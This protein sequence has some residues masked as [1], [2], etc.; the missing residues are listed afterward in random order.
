MSKEIDQKVVEMQFDNRNFEQNVQTS[1]STIEKLKSK[2]DFSGSSKGFDELSKAAKNVDLSTISDKLDGIE[3]KIKNTFSFENLLKITGVERFANHLLDTVQ[4]TFKSLTTENLAAG[5]EKFD[6]KTSG[7]ATLTSQGFAL[8]EVNAQLERLNWFTDETSYNF[9]DMEREI[10]KFTA[11]GQGLEES[12]TAMEGIAS[13]AA[14]SGQKATTASRAM[15]QLSQAMSKGALKYDDYRSIQNASMDT[16]EFRLEAAKTAAELGILEQT[17]EDTFRLMSYDD[18]GNFTGYSKEYSLNDLFTSD[19]LTQQQ[20]FDTDV[21]MGVFTKYA[22]AADG[23]YEFMNSEAGE[24][25]DTV[26]EAMSAIEKEA[27]DY[28]KQMN[29]TGRE[30]SFDEALAELGY[31]FDSFALKAFKAGQEARSFADVLDATKD[32]VSTGWMNTFQNIFGD[33]EQAK[34]LWTDLATSFYNIFASGAEERNKVLKE[35]SQAW[36]LFDTAGN[37]INGRDLLFGNTKTFK[38]ALWIVI[39][40]IQTL[41]DAFNEAKEEIFGGLSKD[42]LIDLSKGIYYL[43][44]SIEITEE[45]AE[46]FKRTFKGMFAIIDVV[47][48]IIKTV[49]SSALKLVNKLMGKSDQSVLDLSADLGDQLVLFREWYYTVKDDF[50]AALDTISNV[51]LGAK[52]KVEEFFGVVENT[53]AYVAVQDVFF[54]IGTILQTFVDD[55]INGRITLDSFFTVL[56]QVWNV[57]SDS[58]GFIIDKI[59]EAVE[60][61]KGFFDTLDINWDVVQL[62]G[63]GALLLLFAH[64]FSKMHE[65]FE[66]P[67]ERLGELISGFSS[68]MKGFASDLKAHSIMMIAEAIAILAISIAALAMLPIENVWSALG[69]IAALGVALLAFSITISKVGK[70]GD[71]KQAASGAIILGVA[72]AIAIV[73]AVTKMIMGVDAESLDRSLTIIFGIGTFLAVLAAGLTVISGRLSTK[74]FKISGGDKAGKIVLGLAASML[75]IGLAIKLIASIDT[76]DIVKGLAVIGIISLFFT[77]VA[78]ASRS[79]ERSLNQTTLANGITNQHGKSG[80][81]GIGST[82]VALAASMLIISAAIKSIAKINNSDLEKGLSVIATM[83]LIFAGVMAL[84]GLVGIN[85]SKAGGLFLGLS[86][87]LLIMTAVIK[88]IAGI[89]KSEL[90]TGV[91]NLN[92]VIFMFGLVMAASHFAG[93]N[94]AKAG[95]MF[96][97]MSVAL[98]ILTGVIKL[99][100]NIDPAGLA[101]GVAAIDALGLM[102]GAVMA[103]SALTGDSKDVLTVL[104]VDLGLL[105]LA[106]GVLSAMEPGRLLAAAG[107]MVMVLAALA[108]VLVATKFA[109]TSNDTDDL[110]STIAGIGILVA[111]IGIILAALS[112]LPLQNTLANAAALSI[113]FLSLAGAMMMIGKVEPFKKGVFASTQI[114]ALVLTEISAILLLF[115]FGLSALGVPIE[116]LITSA[117]ALAVLFGVFGGVFAIISAVGPFASGALASSQIMALA[118][119]EVAAVLVAYSFGLNALGV[120]METLVISASVLAVLLGT[121]GGVFAILSAIGPFA[122]GAM[123]SSQIMALTMIEIAG[124]LVAFG[125]GLTAL[126]IPM[127]TLVISAGTLAVLFGVFGGVF[128]ILSAI[129]PFASGAMASTQIMSLTMLEIAGVLLAFVYGINSLGIP[130]DTLIMSSV[131]LSIL[132][133]AFGGVFAIIAALSPLAATAIAGVGVFAAFIAIMFGI[134]VGIGELVK[135]IQGLGE[136]ISTGISILGDIGLGIGKFVGNIVA[137]VLGNGLGGA[138][139]IIADSLNY[140]G[141]K[142][143]PFLESMSNVPK[144][145][146]DGVGTIAAIILELSGASIVDAFSSFLGAGLNPVG[147]ILDA[148]SSGNRGDGIDHFTVMLSSLAN[149]VKVFAEATKDIDVDPERV[150]NVA[151]AALA[152]A[153]AESAIPKH[154]GVVSWF[155]GDNSL[156]SFSTGIT[157]LAEGLSTFVEKTKNIK[158]SSIDKIKNSTEAISCLVELSK[159]LPK[160]NGVLQFFT[161]HPG[162]LIAFGSEM[163][164][165]GYYI[166]QYTE[167][168]KDTDFN[169]VEESTTAGKLIIDMASQLPAHNGLLQ[170]ILGDNDLS[171]FG[172]SLKDFADGMVEYSKKI[173]GLNVEAI[174]K[175]KDAAQL[176]SD[177]EAGL[178]ATSDSIS[179]W[180]FGGQSLDEFGEKLPKLADGIKQFSD[181]ITEGDGINKAAINSATTALEVLSNIESNLPETTGVF[182]WLTG[183]DK[184]ID[185]FTKDMPKFAEGI[186]KFSD[187]L[188][189]DGGIDSTAVDAAA[190]AMSALSLLSTVQKITDAK[191]VTGKLPDMAEDL[192]AYSDILK[193]GDGFDP[194]TVDNVTDAVK[195]IYA[196]EN[197]LVD[198]DFTRIS[199]GFKKLTDLVN[200]LAR[201]S[202]LDSEKIT[203]FGESLKT[204]ADGGIS[205]FFNAFESSDDRL[206]DS[207]VSMLNAFVRG[208]QENESKFTEVFTSLSSAGAGAINSKYDEYKEAGK[209]I[210]SGIS[211]GITEG[212]SEIEKA[213]TGV[214][215]SN[216][217]ATQTNATSNSYL[218]TSALNGMKAADSASAGGIDIMSMVTGGLNFS[219]F[220]ATSVLGGLTNAFKSPE[221][222]EALSGVGSD[223]GSTI[224]GGLSNF[225]FT[226]TID[227]LT[228]GL[229]NAFKS[230]ESTEA[231]SGVGSDIGSTIFGGLSD[232]NI[233]DGV[234]GF[235]GNITGNENGFASEENVL[236]LTTAGSGIGDKVL[237]GLSGKNG[238]FT[239]A[240]ADAIQGF[241]DGMDSKSIEVFGTS[242]QV[243]LS[244]ADAMKEKL[245]EH[246]PSRVFYGIGSFAGQ[247]F[248]NALDDFIDISYRSG[249][250]VAESAAEGLKETFGNVASSFDTSVEV[251]PTIRPVV[252]LTDVESGA[253]SIDSFFSAERSIALAGST[254]ISMRANEAGMSGSLSVDNSDVVTAIKD[255]RNDMGIMA[256]N[257]S[258]LQI[259]LDTGA[260]AGGLASPLDSVLGVRAARR[261]RS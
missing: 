126:N 151:Q 148:I 45:K 18:L 49:F 259:V 216:S 135:N 60:T 140:F 222:T 200:L 52:D 98:L 56:S 23:L 223:I 55:L 94:A 163:A 112:L 7:V 179:K 65:L 22:K 37:E 88:Q 247:G 160:D 111:E 227:G 6:E 219:N 129:G 251:Q 185:G 235:L 229:T 117:G 198:S 83:S 193:G 24:A 162:S 8:E 72:A 243:A 91:S 202:S 145:A 211:E 245:M 32:A 209:N 224:F 97:G 115:S 152:L 43:A 240:G 105:M 86:V 89:E 5:W 100:E 19:L 186:K 66:S 214:L 48:D 47:A 161:G 114:M 178:P 26:S 138:L 261:G 165:F 156:E 121:F 190:N 175:S 195:D 168:I 196:L 194:V 84:S 177:L 118:M 82:F 14:L 231:L 197:D 228:G 51:I 17:A 13:W 20:W 226:E 58:F 29:E 158:S 74:A 142:I 57:I 248:V 255:L 206:Y 36:T 85:A 30:I 254:D 54:K 170:S 63:I 75:L 96:I 242:A 167:K 68:V 2:L 69:V 79:I 149:G 189:M 27:E 108:G 144:E 59:N 122:S 174:K 93:A 169:R 133:A 239:Q 141:E 44:Q 176:L 12:V 221:S 187:A 215:S 131:S 53:D 39:D 116:T 237:T 67:I 218:P 155:T 119:A 236:K 71:V 92:R 180:L 217:T 208:A 257:L 184:D 99:M 139:V 136:A 81:S 253:R 90:D 3:Q 125:Y 80:L 153:Q 232:F 110:T 78:V 220:D 107:S 35:W 134:I 250:G 164:E 137:G 104:T 132:F 106:L 40:S 159:T 192:K 130:M 103:L 246:S 25:Y 41:I 77:I 258:K 238:E 173:D 28:V 21:M 183:G 234:D 191:E 70:I 188:T 16:K 181:K 213:L 15:Y 256:D 62:I 252:D 109:G 113:L 1:M 127:E 147:T 233:K 244:S 249:A 205:E 76:T 87:S 150:G 61:V 182:G 34:T 42:K 166:T 143:K 123:A 128:A 46:K 4:S 120:P 199:A 201:I 124:I 101:R 230:P 203:S 157:Q 171:K 102:M 212:K 33:Y 260:L 241:I 95:V 38:G 146:L 11:T 204:V 50:Q 31:N 10:G 207:A 154:G 172:A 64:H 73:V 225:N 210:A 9:V